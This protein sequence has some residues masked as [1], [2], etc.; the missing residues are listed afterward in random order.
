MR[1]PPLRPSTSRNSPSPAT[2]TSSTSSCRA[3]PSVP[4]ALF[5]PHVSP[6][7]A[8]RSASASAARTLPLARV[9]WIILTL[10]FLSTVINYIDRQA[11]SVLLPTL[12]SELKL[13]SADYGTI[14]TIFLLAYTVG[15]LVAGVWIDKVG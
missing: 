9:R 3:V 11:L 14:T 13:T 1:P 5:V 8:S 15:Q 2:A 4:S 12:R 6:V 7:S 10:L